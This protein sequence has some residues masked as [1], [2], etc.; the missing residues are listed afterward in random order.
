MDVKEFVVTPELDGV[1]LDKAAAALAS[2]LSRARLKK[3][4]DDGRVRVN[5]RRLPK[6]ALVTKGDVLSIETSGIPDPDAPAVATPDAPLEVRFESPEVLVIDKPAGQPTAPLRPGET[7][8][9]ANALLGRYPELLGVGY[10]PREPGLLH[11]LDT[12]T[13]GL[14]IVAR[15]KAVFDTLRAAL[16]EGRVEKSYLLVCEG[17]DLPDEGIIA[18]PIAN[19]PKDQRRVHA[20]VHPRDV[21]RLHPRPAS[22]RYRV[23]RRAG[24]WAL[25]EARIEKALRHQ[26]RVHFGAIEHPLVGDKL[27]G[28]T[29]VRGLE[30]HALHASLVAFAGA[31]GVPAF[32]VESPLPGELEGLLAE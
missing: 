3:A 26:I 22:T 8:T 27:Y 24:Q 2:G 11:R 32:R 30:R 19:H 7:G 18:F 13:S 9:V 6:G 28:G 29:P 23:L 10:G 16:Q 14:V 5:G 31:E 17:R 25:V 21:M 4:I 15:S 20:C 1:R 12:D